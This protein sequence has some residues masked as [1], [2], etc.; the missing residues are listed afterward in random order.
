MDETIFLVQHGIA[1][2]AS[3]DPQRG[4]TAAGRDEVERIAAWAAR[5]P[6]AV[7]Q[8]RHSGK[9][10][11]AQT[12]AIL[13]K[14]LTPPDGVVET[15]GLAPNDDD[16]PVAASLAAEAS[17]LMLVGHLPFLARL[18]GTLTV[19][20]AESSVIAFRNAG[21]VCLRREGERWRVAWSINPEL[22][23]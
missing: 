16:A 6:A 12:A 22:L 11:A 19:G 20:D 8:I 7:R 2:S 13:A 4:L 17:G 14:Q 23:E 10:R 5:S 15:H 1:A 9:L 3:D 18:A 21:I